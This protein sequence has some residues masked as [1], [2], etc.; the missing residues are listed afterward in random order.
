MTIAEAIPTAVLHSFSPFRRLE[1]RELLLTRL[2][3]R[4]DAEYLTRP[5]VTVLAYPGRSASQSTSTDFG[6]A[7]A[8]PADTSNAVPE[9]NVTVP[10]KRRAFDGRPKPP[11]RE[12]TIPR[13]TRPALVCG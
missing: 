4:S 6:H 2:A 1:H 10:S 9:A 12:G 8:I 5:R 7:R 13:L 3:E 11:G